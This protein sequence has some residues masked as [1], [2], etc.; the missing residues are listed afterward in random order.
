[1]T[2]STPDPAGFPRAAFL[3]L[4]LLAFVLRLGTNLSRV[5]ENFA[6]GIYRGSVAAAMTEGAPIWP[7]HLAEI[8][9]VPGSI[10]VPVLAAPFYLLLGP[11]TL[12]LRFGGTIFHLAALAAWMVLLHRRLGRRAAILGGAL[13]VLAPPGFAK[14]A[15][16]SYGDHVESLPF[17]L[18]AAIHALDWA[19]A[20][21]AARWRT[22]FLAGLGVALAIS[23]HLQATLGIAALA[24]ACA[25][26]AV[27]RLREGAFWKELFLGFLPGAAAGAVPGFL[28]FWFTGTSAL[29]LWGGSPTQ[30]VQVGGGRLAEIGAKLGSLLRDGYSLSFQWDPRGIADATLLFAMACAAALAA[31]SAARW[32]RGASGRAILARAAFFVA[33]PVVF[34][35]VFA[36]SSA[37]FQIQ[38]GNA[39]ALEVRYALPALPFLLLPI[40]VAAAQLWESNRPWLAAA[41]AGPALALG[42]AGSLSTWDAA[43]ILREPARRGY[44]WEEFDSHFLYGTLSPED[45]R[46]VRDRARGK[47]RLPEIEDAL[48]GFV[49]SRGHA[50]KVLEF[51]KRFDT[52][53]EWTWPLRYVPPRLPIGS[54]PAGA[55]AAARWLREVPERLRAYRAVAAG[56]ALGG[57]D[58]FAPNAFAVLWRSAASPEERRHLAI[59]FGRGLLQVSADGLPPVPRFFD[60]AK[61][62]ARL[63]SLPAETPRGEVAF[64][65][66]FRVGMVVNAFFPPGD[67]LIRKAVAHFP[68]EALAGFARGLGAGYRMRFLAPPPRDTSSPG[69]ARVAALL[70]PE[71]EPAFR[72]GLGGAR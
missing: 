34:S 61:A 26:V 37:S 2:E 51:V 22:P 48:E 13:F 3:W 23:F 52:T 64:G 71:A 57:A 17:I 44:L 12:A 18:F 36:A 11:T 43:T 10:V 21:G 24:A 54:P 49:A 14:M 20:R 65:L 42:A 50:A 60:G 56:E 35:L 40:A 28:L 63:S 5:D 72:D 68:R 45:Q 31:A 8:P 55:D 4:L 25:L 15:V 29:S 62:A 30:H 6:E 38:A 47:A 39:N 16:L 32:R 46:A 69:A 1:M 67:E 70:P 59:G 41:V 53:E 58:P 33:Y 27:P 9:H 66:G 7:R 19:D